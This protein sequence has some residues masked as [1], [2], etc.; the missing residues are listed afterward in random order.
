MFIN[1]Y[2]NLF[3]IGRLL[4]QNRK[5]TKDELNSMVRFGADTVFKAQVCMC[6][7][8]FVIQ[9]WN[10]NTFDYEAVTMKCVGVNN[11]RR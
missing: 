2:V 1:Y 6:S 5:L 11:Y 4:Q 3:S 7:L 9:S 8:N 10:K